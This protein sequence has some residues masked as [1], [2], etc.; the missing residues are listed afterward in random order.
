VS[1]I[2]DFI[3]RKGRFLNWKIA[4][5]F[6]KGITKTKKK[7]YFRAGEIP[8]A[9]YRFLIYFKIIESIPDL[10][11]DRNI[12]QLIRELTSQSDKNIIAGHL[13]RL[14]I[15]DQYPIELTECRQMGNKFPSSNVRIKNYSSVN[16][17]EETFLKMLQSFEY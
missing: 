3:D 11:K 7:K 6:S 14:L 12:D 5:G 8:E 10:K 9:F 17:I 16:T 1:T 15:D 4:H 2:V 13:R